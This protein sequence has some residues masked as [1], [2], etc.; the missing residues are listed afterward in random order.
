MKETSGAIGKFGQSELL[1][2]PRIRAVI[3]G[4]GDHGR[5]LYFLL[6][7][8]YG[9]KGI[10]SLED[11]VF[12]DPVIK[13]GQLID[14]LYGNVVGADDHLGELVMRDR[15]VL[16]NGIG[17]VGKIGARAA[18][19]NKFHYAGPAP[20]VQIRA[21]ED[22][23]RAKILRAWA[24]G[25]TSD[26]GWTFGVYRHPSAVVDTGHI[27]QGDQFMAGSVVQVGA[28]I[29]ANVLVN[30]GATIDHDCVIGDHCHIAPGAVLSGRVTVGTRTHIGTGARVIQGVNIGSDCVIG[31][32]AVVVRDVLDGMTV[33]GCPAE[34]IKEYSL[35]RRIDGLERENAALRS[36]LGLTA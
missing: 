7:G 33:V 30:T 14:G 25:K 34:P 20:D 28:V 35:R 12:T 24:P 19:F 36:K 27:C 17:S 16:Y 15:V 22:F 31:A 2:N 21:G 18:V 4:A 29:G 26:H 32:G 13:P 10:H 11:V 23:A 9:H 8:E 5:L 6:C 1:P 3:L